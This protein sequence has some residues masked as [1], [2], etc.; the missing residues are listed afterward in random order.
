MDSRT[1]SADPAERLT[2][3]VLDGHI[4]V[5]GGESLSLGRTFGEHEAYDPATAP[6]GP[7][8]PV[9]PRPR[10]GLA[11]A[12]VSGR[13]YVIGG[14]ARAGALTFVSLTDLVEVFP[15]RSE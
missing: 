8:S 13:W 3:G 6:S 9:C 10:H 5:T 1:G 11:S 15:A 2:A 14:G 4:H 12:V 7:H